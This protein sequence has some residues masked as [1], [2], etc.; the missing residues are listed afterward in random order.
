MSI[1]TLMIAERLDATCVA[2]LRDGIARAIADHARVL[3]ITNAPGQFCLGMSF[4]PVPT[5]DALRAFA[6]VMRA[7]LLAPLPT[8]AVVDGPAFGGG[9]GVAAACDYVLASPTTRFALPEAIYGLAPAIIR[10]ALLRRLSPQRLA[11]LV[12]TIRSRSADEALALG[13]VDEI[14]DP[15]AQHAIVRQLRRAN[16]DSITALRRFEASALEAALA[17]GVDETAYALSRPEVRTALSEDAP[18]M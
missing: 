12:A 3:V 11:M 17:A 5:R 9:L 2:S 1:A 7:I 14:A 4:T 13:L 10:P 6:E 18:W 16:P 8:L 15:S